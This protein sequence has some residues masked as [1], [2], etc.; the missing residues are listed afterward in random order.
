MVINNFYKRDMLY[1]EV[2]SE[3]VTVVAGRYG[4]SDVAIRHACKRLEVPVPPRGYWAK[5]AAGK[6]PRRKQLPAYD[7]PQIIWRPQSRP[8]RPK[9]AP[10]EQLAFLEGEERAKVLQLCAT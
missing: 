5:L 7:G 3:P 4:V 2:W 1:E 6:N 10:V 8:T 9:P